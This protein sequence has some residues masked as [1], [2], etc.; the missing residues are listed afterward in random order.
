MKKAIIFEAG[1]ADP[2]R[3]RF[4]RKDLT[5]VVVD[6]SDLL[7][8]VAVGLAREGAKLIELCGGVSPRWR[9]LVGA[10]VGPNVRVSSVTFGIESLVPAA[11]FN[12]A[13]NA[14][15]PPHA[16]FIFIEKGA[17]PARDR[18][19]KSFPPQETTFI[20]VPDEKAAVAV[21]R[22]LIAD[23][24]G[25]IELY[26]GFTSEGAAA[27]IDAVD[28]RAPVGVGSFT[29]EATFPPGESA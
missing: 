5:I 7:P 2:A 15:K 28:G 18:F 9:P 22:A 20:P 13:Y 29:L 1:G 14:G 26:G 11:Q 6:H 23:G 17:D 21:A 16:A 4:V 8:E 25:L 10:A 12:Q 24:V 19:D 27:V 3:D